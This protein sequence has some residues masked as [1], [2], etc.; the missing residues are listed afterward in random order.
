MGGLYL[1]LGFLF[2]GGSFGGYLQ[3]IGRLVGAQMGGIR[4]FLPGGEVTMENELGYWSALKKMLL[5]NARQLDLVQLVIPDA[6]RVDNHDRSVHTDA[7]TAAGDVDHPLWIAEAVPSMSAVQRTQVL[8]QIHDRL[9]AHTVAVG[10]D[11]KLPSIRRNTWN[12]LCH[13]HS[14][15]VDDWVDFGIGRT[16]KQKEI[17]DWGSCTQSLP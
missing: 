7:Q 1:A 12:H 5:V 15:L 11:E 13:R 16:K 6:I 2:E 14:S 10:A 9:A 17:G 3:G 8:E 4:R